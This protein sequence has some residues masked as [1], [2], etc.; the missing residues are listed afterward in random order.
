[1]GTNYYTK[2]N[3]CSCCGRNDD[4]HLGKSSGGWQ[5]SFQYNSGEFYKN[6]KE[7][8]EWLKD[9]KITDEYGDIV[10]HG[11]FWK[12]VKRKQT[13]NN[14]NHAQEMHNEYPSAR[15]EEL[16]IGGYSFSDCEFS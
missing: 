7:M 11:A 2:I 13:P 8:K 9:K 12:M 3:D 1:M 4:I 6:V 15:D 5:F 10:T 16:I 14:L